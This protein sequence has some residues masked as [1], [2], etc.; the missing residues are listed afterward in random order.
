MIKALNLVKFLYLFKKT[1]IIN[2]FHVYIQ[3]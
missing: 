3:K 1:K 2:V